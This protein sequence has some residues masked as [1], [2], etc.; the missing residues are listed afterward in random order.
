MI[1]AALL[2]FVGLCFS[3]WTSNSQ[4]ILQLTSPDRLRGRVLGLYLFV[5]AGLAPIGGLLAGVLAD[6]GGTELA[7]AVAGLSGLGARARS[8][9][10]ARGVKRLCRAGASRR[11][12]GGRAPRRR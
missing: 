2:F 9:P 12:S 11:W 7:F 3:V 6:I 10:R 1:A 8:R 5:F 4:S